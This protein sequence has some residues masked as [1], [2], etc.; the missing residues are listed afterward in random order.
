M[1]F[2]I[3]SSVVDFDFGEVGVLSRGR[4]IVNIVQFCPNACG[5]NRICQDH[6]HTMLHT[7]RITI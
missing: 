3:P 5:F 6:F 1:F 7:R 4:K 2:A